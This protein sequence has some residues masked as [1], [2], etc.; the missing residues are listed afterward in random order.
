MTSKILLKS[1]TEYMN[2]YQPIYQPLYPLLMNR[3]QAYSEEVGTVAYK[4]LEA[5]GDIRTK[6]ITPKDS[7]MHA[8][9]AIET[10]KTF[11]KYFLGASFVQ[12]TLQSREQNESVVAQILDENQ[13]LM[14]Q[15]ALYGEGS[16]DGTVINNGLF[17]SGDVNH[18]TESSVEIAK[19]AA[20]D[21][22]KDMHTKIMITVNKANQI[23][24]QKVLILYGA[25][26]CAK[27]DSLYANSDAP[28]KDVLAKVLGAGWQVVKM[29]Q[30]VFPA[31]GDGW[32]AVNLDQ[33]KVNH[34]ALP[35]L[36][37]QG[38]NEEKMH[39]WHNFLM[40]SIMIDCLVMNAVIRQPVT[41]AV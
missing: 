19:G 16:S 13:K 10:N 21:H 23:A 5:A 30:D 28:F 14:D 31:S 40:G 24:G 2:D 37:A 7:E 1:A 27:Y 11:K 22:L 39:V 26:A 17:Y 36:K 34:V 9:A 38:V 32:I 18:T 41:F 20:L 4:R 35:Q 12:S 15:L 6:H 8:I 29:P 33:I 3:A 25:T